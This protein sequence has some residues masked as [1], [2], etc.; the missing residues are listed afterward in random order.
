MAA[1][2]AAAPVINPVAPATATAPA[3]AAPPAAAAPP[4]GL[5]SATLAA[6]PLAAP[7]AAVSGAPGAAPLAGPAAPAAAASTAAIGA[8]APPPS[9]ASGSQASTSASTAAERKAAAA[10]EPAAAAA[11]AAQGAAGPSRSDAATRPDGGPGDPAGPAA[12]SGPAG[13]RA[14]AP[15]RVEIPERVPGAAVVNN[16]VR[17]IAGPAAPGAA[18]A[19]ALLQPSLAWAPIGQMTIDRGAFDS[20][21]GLGASVADSRAAQTRLDGSYR[22]VNQEVQAEAALEQGVV[23]SSVVVSTGLSVGYVLWLARGGALLASIASAIPVWTSVDPLPVLSKQ[24]KRGSG[25]R[26]PEDSGH[27]AENAGMPGSGKDD[28]E[29]MFGAA[30][31]G[32]AVRARAAMAASTSAPAGS[33]PGNPPGTE[34]DPA[35]HAMPA[36]ARATTG[37][38]S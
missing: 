21:L 22:Q 34:P 10:A 28:V 6:A 23:A 12:P 19:E 1:T 20:A 24:R 37:V 16:L 35:P 14:E 33:T 29:R 2:S 30:A 27:D 5:A 4:P 25:D 36:A 13:P 26:D 38:P 11:A 7:D 3:P 9:A 31:G 18:A 17:W 8:T 15:I 32:S